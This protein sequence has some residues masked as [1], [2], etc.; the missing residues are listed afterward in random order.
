MAVKEYLSTITVTR[1]EIAEMNLVQ[2]QMLKAVR[3]KQKLKVV[4]DGFNALSLTAGAIGIFLT[5]GA[6][7]AVGLGSAVCGVIGSYTG[8]NKIL[9]SVLAAGGESLAMFMG[10]ALQNPIYDMFEITFPF[11]EFTD[12]NVRFIQGAGTIKR[13]HCRN[14]W[15]IYH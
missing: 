15:I 7:T 14:G 1:A 13:V 5:G 8:Y 10:V 11:L 4:Q 3:E 6:A 12:K 9:E 2:Q